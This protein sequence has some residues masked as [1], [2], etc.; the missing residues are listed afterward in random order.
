MLRKIVFM[1]FTDL[2]SLFRRG[3]SVPGQMPQNRAVSLYGSLQR[4]PPD[5]DLKHAWLAR[6]PQRIKQYAG[7]LNHGLIRERTPDWVLE[8]QLM[9]IE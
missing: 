5:S 1:R 9:D 6:L 2:F 4:Y 8:G 7:R 3:I